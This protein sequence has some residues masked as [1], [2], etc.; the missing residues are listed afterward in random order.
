MKKHFSVIVILTLAAIW[1]STWLGIKVSIDHFPPFFAAGSRFLIAFLFLYLILRIKNIPFPDSRGAWRITLF[2][3][4]QQT[5]IYGL[6]FWGEQ[7]I[8]SGISAVLFSTMPFFVLIFSFMMIGKEALYVTHAAGIALSIFGT[9][10]IF[11]PDF[12][13]HPKFIWGFS[14]ILLSAV[15]SSYMAVY[16]KLHAGGI[17]AV[18][19][20]AVQMLVAGILLSLISLFLEP[21]ASVEWS[22]TGFAAILYLGIVGSAVAFALYMWVIK[23]VSPLTASV[24]PLMTPIVALI[25]GWAVLRERMTLPMLSGSGLILAGIYFINTNKGRIRISAARPGKKESDICNSP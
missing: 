8:D 2:T 16:V 21:I 5:V 13:V 19:N 3:G 20:T 6:V 7:Y 24:I 11:N 12:S 22:A 18:T 17:P 10:I 15:V 9:F 23:K 25:I 4:L 14:A 1:G